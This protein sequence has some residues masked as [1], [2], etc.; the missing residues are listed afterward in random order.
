MFSLPC[1]FLSCFSAT[2]ALALLP[3]SAD[4]AGDWI[5]RRGCD[6]LVGGRLWILNARAWPPAGPT[7]LIADAPDGGVVG[8]G[9]RPCVGRTI[10]VHCCAEARGLHAA[11]AV[12]DAGAPGRRCRH[13]RGTASAAPRRPTG[14]G[15]VGNDVLAG[16]RAGGP[17][18]HRRRRTCLLRPGRVGLAAHAVASGWA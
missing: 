16:G 5:S 14:D 18:A 15:P 17:R 2:R 1:R 9:G 6:V 10:G 13:P 8:G 11:E 12:V 4:C 7:T 3:A